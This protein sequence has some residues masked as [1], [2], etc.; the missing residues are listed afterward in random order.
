MKLIVTGGAGFI[1]SHLTEY[2]VGKKHDVIVIDNLKE[3]KLNNLRNV[4]DKIEFLNLDILDYEKLKQTMKNIDGVF[5]EAGLT[6]VNDSFKK[7]KEYF[8]TNVKGTENILKLAERFGF[9]VIFASSASVYGNAKKIPI[10]ENV[11]RN[12]LNPYGKT[13][14]EAEILCDTYRKKGVSVMALRYFNVYGL[15]QNSNY[16]GVITK[17]LDRIADKKPPIIYGD[18][19]QIRDFVYVGDVVRANLFAMTSNSK[20]GSVNIGSGNG[21]SVNQLAKMVIDLSGYK[22]KSIYRDAT[23]GDIRESI[24]DTSLAKK[25]L[26][27]K[28]KTNLKNWLKQVLM[29]MQND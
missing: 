24:A 12:P 17:F 21:I 18:G 27:W 16:A 4:K 3:G 25:L 1:G 10:K 14:V 13:K 7:E 11:R 26:H 28:P 20:I 9:R 29:A 22:I 15:R 6:S 5:H 8:A 23:P 2:L 19:C